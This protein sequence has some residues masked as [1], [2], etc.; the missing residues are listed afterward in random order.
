MMA[1][2]PDVAAFHALFGAYAWSAAASR[3]SNRRLAASS[4]SVSLVWTLRA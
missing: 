3:R 2:V 4:R 1:Q